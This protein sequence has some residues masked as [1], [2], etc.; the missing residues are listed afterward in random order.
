[1]E[2]LSGT[3]FGELKCLVDGAVDD[4]VKA[5]KGNKAAGVRVRKA[6]Q[7]VKLLAHS[8]KKELLT[9]RKKD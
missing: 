5:Q 1:M 7:S 6:L 3:S 2:E 8:I 9:T 4:Y